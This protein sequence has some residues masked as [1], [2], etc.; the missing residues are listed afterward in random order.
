M[1]VRSVIIGSSSTYEKTLILLHGGGGSNQEFIS[2]YNTSMFANLTGFKM[3]F[4]SASLTGGVWYESFKNGCGLNQDCAY[5]IS[6][7]TDQANKLN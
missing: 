3:V 1:E 4:P 5:N 6:S 2:L 7:I